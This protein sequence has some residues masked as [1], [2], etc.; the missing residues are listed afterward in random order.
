MNST[1]EEA[2]FALSPAAQILIT[3]CAHFDIVGLFTCEISLR[4]QG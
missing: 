1:R 3:L 4:L 2:L